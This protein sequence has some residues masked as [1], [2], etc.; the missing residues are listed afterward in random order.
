[1]S[2]DGGLDVIMG[3]PGRLPVRPWLVRLAVVLAV[4]VLAVLALYQRRAR[5]PGVVA[6]PS[7]S[8]TRM[9]VDQVCPVATDGYRTVTVSFRLTNK[10]GA[11]VRLL[12]IE[13]TLVL[14]GMR[15]VATLM[16][17]G[18]CDQPL[19]T[20]ADGTLGPGDTL[21]VIFQF[22]PSPGTC[23]RP[24]PVRARLTVQSAGAEQ[25]TELPVLPDLGGLPFGTCP[26]N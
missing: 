7:P 19:D 5:H 6:Q 9:V 4:V 18:A 23:P 14:G 1:M 3:G 10:G 12:R 15:P 16:T 22:Q 8:A 11:P 26:S 13:P 25:V 17:S 21:M 2:D 20:A 24:L